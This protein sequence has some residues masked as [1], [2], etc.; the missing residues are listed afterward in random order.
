MHLRQSNYRL[1]WLVLSV[2]T[3]QILFGQSSKIL[4]STGNVGVIDAGTNMGIKVGNYFTVY[5]KIGMRWK[6]FTYV[7]A[8]KTR[9]RISR[10]ELIPVAP[11]IQLMA[12]DRVLPV[13]TSTSLSKINSPEVISPIRN[14]S[15][16]IK[17]VYLGPSM[18]IFIPLEGMDNA[19]E[20][21]YC[22]GGVLGLQFRPDMDVNMRFQYSAH[23]DTWSLW[24]IQLLGRRYS[25][26]GFLFDLGYGILYP[27]IWE[28]GFISLGFC[29]G[30]GYTFP[31]TNDT[32]FEFGFLY[33][34][35][36]HFIRDIAQFLT[37]ELR[38]IL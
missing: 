19:F 28:G 14:T 1:A 18:G 35:Y 31:I 38:L 27:Q 9:P 2:L 25:Q 22:Y 23:G 26:D 4:K 37:L 30:F 17:G 11:Q 21:T 12:G 15:E 7:Q 10:V 16:R 36:P 34:Y 20:T 8:T 3:G 33:S 13:K 5:R 32:W 29:G 6:P 24:N